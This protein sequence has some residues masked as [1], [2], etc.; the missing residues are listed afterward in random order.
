MRWLSARVWAAAIAALALSNSASLAA[1]TAT[2]IT[3][4]TVSGTALASYNPFLAPT[5]RL[6][7][8]S[9]ASNVACSVEL[10]FQTSTPAHM[11]GQ[12][13]LLA[14]DVQMQSSTTSLLFSAG[15]PTATI[16][17]DI[18]AGNVGTATVQ[19][20]VPTNQIVAS[21]AYADASLVASLFDRT[22]PATLAPLKSVGAPIS[23]TVVPVCNFESP[24]NP[25]INFSGAITNGL[26]NPNDVKSVTLPSLRCTAPSLLRLSATPMRLTTSAT[27]GVAFDSAINFRATATLTGATAVLD[28]RNGTTAVS[29][30]RNVVAGAT[31]ESSVKVDVSLLVGQPLLAGTYSSVMTVS[32]DPSP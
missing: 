29:T 10:A 5:P 12:G 3:S 11:Q 14:Y 25:T 22:G 16:R 28:T 27:G 23:T 19:V 32:V 17:I 18:A 6:L 13:S 15:M 4:M 26:P 20:A 31:L 1:C 21:G 2:D 8:V 7:T 30:Q 9:V 24:T